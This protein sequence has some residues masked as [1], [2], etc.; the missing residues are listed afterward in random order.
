MHEEED[1]CVVLA[2]A[3]LL[4]LLLLGLLLAMQWVERSL[5]RDTLADQL[6]EF[7]RTAR[8]EDLEAFVR[9]GLAVPVRRY[10]QG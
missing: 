2:V 6:T 10:W 5:S 3:V 7:L 8:P 1:E 4:P 9:D